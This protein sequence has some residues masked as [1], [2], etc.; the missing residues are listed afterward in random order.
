MIIGG[1]SQVIILFIH[2]F[3]LLQNAFPTNIF[4]ICTCKVCTNGYDGGRNLQYFYNLHKLTS[5]AFS[6]CS[7]WEIKIREDVIL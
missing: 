7:S 5:E 6:S 2:M 3:F 4:L 1:Y